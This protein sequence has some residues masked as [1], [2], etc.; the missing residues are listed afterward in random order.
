MHVNARAIIERQCPA[1]A[2]IVLQLRDKPHEGR[3]WIDR[4]A[5]D[6]YLHQVWN[7]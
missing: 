4:A 1:G 6:F 5:L 2:E 7:I 3:T